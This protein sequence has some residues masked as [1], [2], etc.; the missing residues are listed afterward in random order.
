MSSHASATFF[1][2]ALEFDKLEFLLVALV[3]NTREYGRDWVPVVQFHRFW[4]ARTGTV[5]PNRPW[6]FNSRTAL[7]RWLEERGVCELRG[8]F[9]R[10]VSFRLTEVG[11]YQAYYGSYGAGRIAPRDDG[12]VVPV[13]QDLD[14]YLTEIGAYLLGN[15]EGLAQYVQDPHTGAVYTAI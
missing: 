10:H 3:N 8:Q 11:R 12:S 14:A 1:R 15:W 9:Y 5:I 4:K 7:F 2:G 6:T 13:W